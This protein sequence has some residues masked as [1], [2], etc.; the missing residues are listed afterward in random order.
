M[1]QYEKNIHRWG[2]WSLVLA[3]LFFV[4]FPLI[5]SIYFSAWPGFSVVFQ[6]LLAIAPIYWT[7]GVIAALTFSPM[8]GSGGA[9][10]GFVTGNLTAMK[11]PAALRAMQ[12]SET[13]P[14]TPEGEVVSTLAIATSSIVTTIILFLGMLLFTALRPVL[15]SPVLAPAFTNILPALFGA[16]GVVFLARNWKLAIA[17]ILFMS[18]LFILKPSLSSA[19]SV[20]VP[21]SAAI[22]VLA[23]RILYK[24][25]LI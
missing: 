23:G 4:S 20:L 8:L 10:L 6:G 14:G 19:V 1:N 22:T 2:R 25:K 9:Y 11:V 13:R 5:S 7:V 24:K 15:E 12:V 17:P 18:L 3:I 16:L 21:V